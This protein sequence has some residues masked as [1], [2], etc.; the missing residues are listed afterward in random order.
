M[1]IFGTLFR[2]VWLMFMWPFMALVFV[3]TILNSKEAEDITSTAVVFTEGIDVK[4]HARS[5]TNFL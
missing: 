4:H 5:V 1:R 2:L 3:L